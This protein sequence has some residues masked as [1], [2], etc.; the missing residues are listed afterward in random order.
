MLKV[1]EI[2]T[3]KKLQNK[4]WPNIVWTVKQVRSRSHSNE[5][6]IEQLV[7][8]LLVIHCVFT[9]LYELSRVKGWL[10]KR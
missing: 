6:Q 9:Y 8:L 4:K 1:V 3:E 10:C 5:Q 7:E 2:F